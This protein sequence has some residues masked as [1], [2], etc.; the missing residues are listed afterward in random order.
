MQG[1]GVSVTSQAGSP[2]PWCERDLPGGKS[3]AVCER[4]LPGRKSGAVV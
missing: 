4:D 2:G 1:R 3:G